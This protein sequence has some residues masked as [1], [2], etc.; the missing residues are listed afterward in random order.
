[1]PVPPKETTRDPLLAAGAYLVAPSLQ[2]TRN[3]VA[4]LAEIDAPATRSEAADETAVPEPQ[5][6][7]A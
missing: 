6:A 7:P 4:I 3:Q 2:E 1:M 5:A